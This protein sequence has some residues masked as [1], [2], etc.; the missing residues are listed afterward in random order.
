MEPQTPKPTPTVSWFWKWFLNNQTV[1]V[2]LIMLLLL[3][4]VYAL[5]KIAYLFSPIKE[6]F[7]II[8]FPVVGAGIIYYMVKPLQDF[9]LKKGVPKWASILLIFVLLMLLVVAA[10]FSFIPIL[11]R[12]LSELLNQLPHYYQI[13]SE[14]VE[15][16]IHSAAF[17]NFQEQLNRVNMDF[18]Q[19]LTTRL[20][21]VLNVTVSGIGSVVGAVGDIVIGLITMPI[22]LYYLLQ[23]GERLLPKVIR[24]FPTRSRNRIGQVLIEMNQQISSYIRGQLTVA[25]AVA[26]MFMIGYAVI[27]LPYGMTIAMIAGALNVIPYVGSF[28]G[29]LPAMI[30][31]IVISPVMFLQVCIVFM[32]EQTLEGRIISPLILGNSL[33]M[34]PVTILVVLLTTGKMFGLVGLLLGVP[35][36]A[37]LKVIVTHIF[38][39]YQ[40][41]SGLYSTVPQK[42]HSTECAE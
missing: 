28:F 8:G 2:L 9:L 5:T 29:I 16:V 36:Y 40:E 1:S 18:L 39:W 41:Y 27:G 34:H 11:E 23:D 10:I 37:V 3:M 19:S 17:S 6:F 33:Q 7:S 22:L 30:V 31:G 38:D 15:T 14:Q 42:N 26:V 4:N 21:G 20:N 13:I 25:M 24:I 12:Q 32:I 35:G